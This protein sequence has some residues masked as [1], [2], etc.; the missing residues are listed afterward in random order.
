MRNYIGELKARGYTLKQLATETGVPSKRL[1]AAARGISPFRSGSKLYEAVRNAN[2]RLGYREARAAG[3]T[4]E[5][6]SA[7][8]RTIFDPEL[9][10]I[11]I[12]TE[13]LVKA[14]QKTTRYQ[15]RLLGEFYNP[16]EKKTKIQE[17]FSRAYLQIDNEKMDEEAVNDARLKLGGTNWELRRVIEREIIEYILTG[18]DA[19]EAVLNETPDGGG[20][21]GGRDSDDDEEFDE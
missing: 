13:K 5:R 20:T 8:R 19:A 7:S 21:F 16:K 15:V 17:G 4:S 6:A 11:E 18:E 2:R 1:S 9:K 3:M 12:T 14:K 10:P